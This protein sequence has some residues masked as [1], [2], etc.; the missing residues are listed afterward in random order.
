MPGLEVFV[1]GQCVVNLFV[2]VGDSDCY[3]TDC[4][5]DFFDP[6]RI[7]ETPSS[8]RDLLLGLREDEVSFSVGCLL[9]SSKDA[10]AEDSIQGFEHLIE[11]D[12]F[13]VELGHSYARTSSQ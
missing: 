13:D 5:V 12:D 11:V 2:A 6:A 8:H 7:A 3:L 4:V 9:R 1:D 10:W